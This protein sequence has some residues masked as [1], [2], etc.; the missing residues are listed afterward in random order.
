MK[1]LLNNPIVALIL[2]CLSLFYMYWNVLRPIMGWDKDNNKYQT[3]QS[4]EEESDE[5]DGE[6]EVDT[7]KQTLYDSNVVNKFTPDWVFSYSRDPFKVENRRKYAKL[8]DLRDKPKSKQKFR[9]YRRKRISNQDNIQ[10]VS[11]GPK[12]QLVI[13]NGK[14]IKLDNTPSIH[15]DTVKFMLE[16]STKKLIFKPKA[17]K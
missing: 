8:I 6:N 17:S 11:I 13:I 4:I 14:T 15:K 1:K 2:V 5:Q 3:N 9:S 10:A 7:L 16:N 12:G